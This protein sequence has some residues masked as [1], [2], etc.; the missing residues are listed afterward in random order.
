MYTPIAPRDKSIRG[1]VKSHVHLKDYIDLIY[2]L[3]TGEPYNQLMAITMLLH[4]V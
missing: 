1:L 3:N 2:I 4:C